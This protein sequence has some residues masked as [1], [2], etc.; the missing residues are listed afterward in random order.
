VV[1]CDDSSPAFSFPDFRHGRRSG[2]NTFRT[3]YYDRRSTQ[4]GSDAP[5][6]DA[7][8]IVRAKQHDQHAIEQLVR[9]YQDVAFRVACVITGDADEAQDAAQ[10]GFIKAIQAL[11]TFR[12]VAPFRPWLLRIVANEAKNRVRSS[13]RRA[14]AP[15]DEQIVSLE[16]SPHEQAE[17]NELQRQL[18]SAVRSLTPDDQ[19]IIAYRYFFDLTEREMADLLECPP[20]TVKSRLSRAT[21]R[22]RETML[23]QEGAS[24]E[25]A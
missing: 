17:R 3:V 9:R 13:A 20:G 1:H 21:A 6:D 22:L 5:I 8:L 2:T 23:A 18:L 19:R 10:T 15:L 16:S 12:S 24:N 14:T 4:R 11:D 25:R 7:E